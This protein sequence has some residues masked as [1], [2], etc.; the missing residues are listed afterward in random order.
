MRDRGR[1]WHRQPWGGVEAR[2]ALFYADG[3]GKSAVNAK[4]PV[5]SGG[6]VHVCARACRQAAAA[7]GL[8]HGPERR[9]RD[10]CRARGAQQSPRPPVARPRPAAARSLRH[11]HG[12]QRAL[13]RELLRR[14]AHRPLFHLRQF[15]SH[16]GRAR[17][18][19]QQQPIQGA[20]HVAGQA[21]RGRRGA[22]ATAPI[23]SFA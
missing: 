11:L 3:K 8:H 16:A 7:A 9:G 18:H 20:D 5:T 2:G 19:S 1:G 6:I 23:S 14:R 13:H 4:A 21:R 15:V 12:K 17:L 10:L 22:Q